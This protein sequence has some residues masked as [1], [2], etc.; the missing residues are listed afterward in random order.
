MLQAAFSQVESRTIRMGF[1]DPA[2]L[3]SSVAAS[4]RANLIF[5]SV[6]VPETEM[7]AV[8]WGG[9]VVDFDDV[10]MTLLAMSFQV[11]AVSTKIPSI[12]VG[13]N[14]TPGPVAGFPCNIGGTGTRYFWGI[15][16]QGM[17][18]FPGDT[19]VLTGQVINT[20]AVNA[21]SI[22]DTLAAVLRVQPVRLATEIAIAALPGQQVDA[23]LVRRLR[24]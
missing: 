9:G 16:L 19:L 15:Q 6:V 13:A 8:S 14:F 11:D 4:A 3:P 24:G 18:F 7:W 20:D 21:H 10:A 1:T 23:N 17:V 2:S 22:V 12:S 5:A